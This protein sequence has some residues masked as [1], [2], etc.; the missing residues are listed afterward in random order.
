[1]KGASLRRFVLSAFGVSV[2]L[3]GTV[4]ASGCSVDEGADGRQPAVA[5]NS[6]SVRAARR[7]YDGAPPVAGHE[8]FGMTCTACHDL[9][10]MPVEGVGFAPAS[11]HDGTDQAYS[12]MRCRQCHVFQL[13]DG[14]FVEN[15]FV[16]LP[17]DLRPGRRLTSLSPPTIPHRIF[18]REN[19]AACHMGPGARTEIVTSHPERNRC[20][21]CHVAVTTPEFFSS[22][23]GEGYA[24]E[25]TR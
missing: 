1:L 11:P 15:S 10:G 2:A 16:G 25:E 24:G 23:A 7:A 4:W 13:D 5:Q 6:A 20:R 8:D 22:V 19:C 21:Q 18:M 17:Q 9:Q 3:I 12:T 14:L